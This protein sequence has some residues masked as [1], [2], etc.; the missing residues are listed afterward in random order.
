MWLDS[1]YSFTINFC[2]ENLPSFAVSTLVPFFR[3]ALP[4]MRNAL[5]SPF[6]DTFEP[7][8][9]VD[10]LSVGPPISFIWWARWA[11]SG[12]LA[13]CEL[14]WPSFGCLKLWMGRWGVSFHF[15]F[16]HFFWCFADRSTYRSFCKLARCHV[17]V[18]VSFPSFLLVK[19]DWIDLG[20]V[21]NSTPLKR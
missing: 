6:A 12:G 15:F 21:R 17:I 1:I 7:K 16:F 2:D 9:D 18:C 3:E 14:K 11:E 5:Y 4:Q 13:R 8:K 20:S 10:L 19:S